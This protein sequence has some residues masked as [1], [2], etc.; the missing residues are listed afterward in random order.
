MF[1][2]QFGTHSIICRQVGGVFPILFCGGGDCGWCD[3][4]MGGKQTSVILARV[5]GVTG[6]TAFPY[7]LLLK[8]YT[9]ISMIH[10]DTYDTYDTEFVSRC[11]STVYENREKQFYYDTSYDT[12]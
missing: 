8:N 10:Y 7:F 12:L 9:L 11:I 6:V 3:D 1:T 5:I 2:A 4:R